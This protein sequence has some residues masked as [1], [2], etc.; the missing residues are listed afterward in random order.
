MI[1]YEKAF[2]KDECETIKNYSTIY[3]QDYDLFGE[4]KNKIIDNKIKTDNFSYNIYLIPNNENTEWLFIKLMKWFEEKSGKKINWNRKIDACTLHK[5]SEGE[6]FERHI[7]IQPG[8]EWRR[9]NIGL[10]LSDENDY[11]G[12]EYSYWDAYETEYIL[13][14]EIGTIIAYDSTIP[15]AVKKITKGIRWSIVMQVP[16]WNFIAEKN[17]GLI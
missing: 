14:K 13:P 15:H 5:Y 11:E 9:Y 7:D 3:N 2:S 17:K 6:F 8:F 16:Y 10:Q 12:G 4:H 1:W